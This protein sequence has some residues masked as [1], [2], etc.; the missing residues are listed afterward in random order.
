MSKTVINNPLVS[1]I[2]NCF[3]GEVF[4]DECIKSVISQSYENWEVI[5][6]DNKSTDRSAEIFN[7]YKDTRLKYFC[8]TE[9]TSLYKARNLAIQRA[10]GKL[11]AFIDCDDLWEKNKLALQVPIFDNLKINLVYSNLWLIK[12]NL[13]NKKKFIKKKSPSGYIY[14][15]LLNEYNLGIITAIF[16]KDIVKGLEKIFDERFS[17]I[18]DFDFFL[19]LSKDHYFHYIDVPLAYYRIHDKNFSSLYKEKEMD[20]FNIWATENTNDI[21]LSIIKRMKDKIALRKLLHFKFNKDYN[22]CYKVLI[23]NYKSLLILK[24]LIIVFTPLYV[25]RKISWFH[26]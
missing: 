21:D 4:L 26:N 7:S 16:R 17:I 15:K 5:F 23:Q 10:K 3:N 18:G 24:M 19:K 9:H 25:L 2:I 1:I 14:K 20:E 13:K 6:W 22:N 11:I 12:N 8:A